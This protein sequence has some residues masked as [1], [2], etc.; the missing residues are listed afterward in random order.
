MTAHPQCWTGTGYAHDTCRE[1]S[2]RPCIERGCGEKAGTLWGP[3]W[4]PTHDVERLD[5]VSGGLA[6][7]AA[8]P[9]SE[10]GDAR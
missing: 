1:P 10:A 4:C 3:L 8:T 9:E 6:G 7:I 5:R 2:G